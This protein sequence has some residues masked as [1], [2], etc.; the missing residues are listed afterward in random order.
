VAT[1]TDTGP[2]VALLDRGQKGH[3]PCANIYRSLTEPLLTTWPCFT[4]AM[5]FLGALG[6]WSKQK[7]LWDLVTNRVLDL[8]TPTAPDSARMRALMEKY[9]DVP[10]A[11]ADASLVAVAETLRLRR[12]FTLD[13]D[14]RVYR[15]NDKEPFEIVP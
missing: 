7:A 12:V 5:H 10:M 6:G 13:S 9:A 3:V 15:A 11:L 2:L 4:E 1:L 8:Y 14:F